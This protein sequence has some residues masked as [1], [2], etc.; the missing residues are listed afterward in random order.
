[1][2]LYR[3]RRAGRWR[4]VAE[5]SITRLIKSSTVRAAV[6]LGAEAGIKVGGRARIKER[7]RRSRV[8]ADVSISWGEAGSRGI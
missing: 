8:S 3:E 6:S 2:R 5:G 1:M 4:S 7:R